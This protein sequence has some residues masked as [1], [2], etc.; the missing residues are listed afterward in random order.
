M[1]DYT[2]CLNQ[3]HATLVAQPKGHYSAAYSGCEGNSQDGT[4]LVAILHSSH[5]DAVDVVGFVQSHCVCESAIDTVKNNLAVQVINELTKPVSTEP[6]AEVE[7]RIREAG[8]KV[9]KGLA[10]AQK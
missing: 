5:V 6:G 9:D 2:Q 8:V 4:T 1:R 7:R 10:F 3:L